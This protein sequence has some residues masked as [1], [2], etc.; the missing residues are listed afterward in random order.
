MDTKNNKLA[1]P[2]YKHPLNCV[3]RGSFLKVFNE[4]NRTHEHSSVKQN[5]IASYCVMLWLNS[6]YIVVT[7]MVSIILKHTD[8]EDYDC[9]SIGLPATRSLYEKDSKQSF[10]K[11]I[12]RHF[13]STVWRWS[14]INVVS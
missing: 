6:T 11:K 2:E 9:Y 3:L 13:S 10:S 1:W 5:L 4:K 12:S 7:S 14:K 8:K